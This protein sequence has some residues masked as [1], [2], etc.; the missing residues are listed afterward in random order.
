MKRSTLF[1]MN[2]FL[3][4]QILTLSLHASYP[5]KFVFLLRNIC[6]KAAKTS[7]L[8]LPTFMGLRKMRETIEKETIDYNDQ[9]LLGYP[10]DKEQQQKLLPLKNEIKDL[11]L[12]T[13]PHAYS[14]CKT[15][16]ALVEY[17]EHNK[18]QALKKL[19]GDQFDFDQDSLQYNI[20]KS[21]KAIQRLYNID[22]DNTN[23]QEQVK[24]ICDMVKKAGYDTDSLVI[25][26]INNKWITLP[27]LT[28]GIYA[29][30]LTPG[31]AHKHNDIYYIKINKKYTQS[32]GVL[33]HEINHILSGDLDFIYKYYTEKIPKMEEDFIS[34]C[35]NASSIRNKI[36]AAKDYRKN[37]LEATQYFLNFSQSAEYVADLK[38]IATN[39]NLTKENKIE[40]L[41]QYAELMEHLLTYQAA[42][43][44]EGQ[45]AT[46]RVFNNTLAQDTVHIP[47]KRT[48]SLYDLTL[49]DE[50]THPSWLSR[51]QLVLR[52]KQLLEEEQK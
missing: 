31:L 52:A 33:L 51:Y 11:A 29:T 18:K 45:A 32:P 25:E 34:E 47:E 5:L 28:P 15:P 48:S 27:T 6:K 2:L 35:K 38:Q 17:V 41:T 37:L 30:I 22:P 26:V 36:K 40:V 23:T 10:F 1:L 21:K 14:S 16:K 19:F 3:C 50:P 24:A 4:L 7:I 13:M 8:C 39:V 49:V 43:Q 12:K 44:S 46:D 9:L 42:S 20:N